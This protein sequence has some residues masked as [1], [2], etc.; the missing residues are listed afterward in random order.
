MRAIKVAESYNSDGC[1]GNAAD[2]ERSRDAPGPATTFL[3]APQVVELNAKQAR[4]EANEA[5]ALS[6]GATLLGR[7][8]V[9]RE[10]GFGPTIWPRSQQ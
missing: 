4:D 6:V 10:R 5:L 3:S 1:R 8:Q 9:R 2:L 7:P